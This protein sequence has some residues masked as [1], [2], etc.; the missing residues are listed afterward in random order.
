MN[1]LRRTV[2]QLV[3]YPIKSCG[4]VPVS[5]AVV[6]RRGFQHDR[7][8][9]I[10]DADHRFM[11]QR[12]HPKLA[13]IQVRINGKVLE[14]SAPNA[15]P[16]TLPLE[17]PGTGTFEATVWDD[18]VR[19]IPGGSKAQAWFTEVLQVDCQPVYMPDESAR[20]V[21]PH[22]ARNRQLVS[23][24]DGFPFLLISEASLEDL[25][26]RLTTPVPMNRFR[27]SLVIRGCTPFEEDT[28]K[29]FRIGETIFHIA[30]PCSR[31]VTTTV[32]QSTGI[33][34]REPLA[35]LARY[36]K[37]DGE[38]LFGQNLIQE[39]GG[40]IRVGDAVEAASE[41]ARQTDFH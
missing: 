4:G 35:T 27:P 13:L 41:N 7:R 39:G 31:C 34:G 19:A 40:R 16:I 36:R 33:M 37:K 23:F 8:W 32:D 29:S 15:A 6:E 5:E 30:K 2:S 28:W 17:L 9:M 10:V 14:I 20:L 11:T 26:G 24:A 1:D 3:I 22:L 25:N 12:K 38:V 21:D 18:T